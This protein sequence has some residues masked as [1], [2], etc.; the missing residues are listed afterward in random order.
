MRALVFSPANLTAPPRPGMN[1]LL[2]WEQQELFLSLASVA[3]AAAAAA[4]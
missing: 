2:H 4:A 1:G 3:A